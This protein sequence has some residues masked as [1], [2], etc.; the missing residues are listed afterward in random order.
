MKWK[1]SVLNAVTN[2]EVEGLMISSFSEQLLNFNEVFMNKIGNYVVTK[3][4]GK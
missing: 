4:S 1:Q 3:N 2:F